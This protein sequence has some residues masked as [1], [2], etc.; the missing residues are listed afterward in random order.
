MMGSAISGMISRVPMHPIDT[1]KARLQVQTASV[2][3]LRSVLDGVRAQGIGSLYHGFPIVSRR[4]VYCSVVWLTRY[5][6]PWPPQAFFGSA[7]A[8]LLY[9]SCYEVTKSWATRE[10]PSAPSAG[11]HFAAGMLAESVSCVLW[12][13]IDVVKERQQVAGVS[14]QR[15]PSTLD[16]IR[17]IVRTEG[18]RG[19]YRGY[20]ATLASFG[21][22]SALYFAFYERLKTGAERATSTARGS[23][24]PLPWQ[25]LCAS[26]A[27]AAA[28]LLTSPLDLVKLRLQVQRA[29]TAAIAAA[30]V[31][32]GPAPWGAPYRGVAHAL[33]E[34]VRL[35]GA[36]ALFRGAGA[37]VAFHAP[38]TALTMTLFET[39]KDAAARLLSRWES[40]QR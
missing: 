24:L 3:G 29:G 17:Q 22:F 10:F 16:V 8:S 9:F 27:G 13:P 33:R 5:T 14:A 37:R 7:P 38:S 20:A 11:V 39:C 6:R 36:P 1:L 21:P 40:A 18:V 15:R 28:S 2:G 30:G 34:V 19:V 35:E 32:P 23:L 12:V 31:G 25:I 26:S 4:V